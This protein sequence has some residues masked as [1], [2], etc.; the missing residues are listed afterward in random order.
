[1]KNTI[2]IVPSE[3]DCKH[4]QYFRIP[5]YDIF[6]F[7]NIQNSWFV[8]S[9]RIYSLY[10]ALNNKLKGIATLHALTRYVMPPN[11]FKKYIFEFKV[12]DKFK[13]PEKL[14]TELGYERVFNVRE[15]GQFAIRGEIIDFIGANEVPT[16]IELFDNEIEEI[17]EFDPST[18]KSIKKLDLALIL[19]AKEYIGNIT[20][21][22]MIGE[23]YQG[24]ILDYNVKLLITDK[25]KVIDEYIKKERE[26]RDLIIDRKLRHKYVMFSGF[27]YQ[28][29][30]KNISGTFKLKKEG[31]KSKKTQKI[32]KE[33]NVPTIPVISEEEI[34][35]GD[36]VVHKQY[37]IAK[38]SGIRKIKNNNFE[39]EYLIL[40]YKDSKL[41]VPIDRLDLVQKYIG[42]KEA[43]QIDKL[44]KNSWHRRV[45]KA[46]K[47]IEK[48]VKEL[49]RINAI[50]KNTK[51]LVIEGDPELEKEFSDTFPHIETEDQLKAI[52]DVMKDLSS[53]KNMDR[54]VAGDAGYGKTE[55]AMRAA[56][57]V[58]VSGK[59]V[60]VLT[61][62]TVLAR[63]HYEN[64]KKRF[65]KF[66]LKVELY[67]SSLTP[68]QKQKVITDVR[69]GITDIVIG[70]HGIFKSLKFSD[71]GLLII[72]EEQKFGVEQKEALKKLRVNVNIL[73]M[74]A[75]PIPRTL[76]MAL[77]GLKDMSV[78]KTPPFG[79]KQ[80]Q[81]IVSKYDPKIIRQAILR[82]INRGGQVLYVHNRVN[83]ID[84]IA[85]KL[86]EIVPEVSIG[87]AHGQ[88]SKR[89]ME[90]TVHE[91]YN[92][93]IDVLVATTIIENGIDIPNANTLIVDDAHRY[94]ISQLYQLRGRVGRSDK[95]AFAYFLYSG[96]LNKIANERLK[97]I[98]EIVGPGSG[99]QIALRDMEI[100]GIGNILGLEQHGFINDIGLHYYFEILDE[101][102]DELQGK[103][104][105]K[106]ETEISGMQGSVVIPENYIYDP[107]ERIRLYRRIASLTSTDEIKEI[108]EE[109]KDRFGDIPQSV[110]NLLKY[111]KL[112][113][114][115]SKCGIKKI[116]IEDSGLILYTENTL[117]INLPYIYNEKEK[118]YIIYSDEESLIKEL[119]KVEQE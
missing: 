93:N 61:P 28:K 113:I 46:R 50:R 77:S 99:F 112:R 12:G 71:L 82:E 48:T 72:D 78:I 60:A 64:F 53:D 8:K 57:K 14:F 7:E 69:K 67:D 35:I 118:A 111:T 91:F 10:L 21:E 49:L 17:R 84:E 85:A 51:G 105:F 44:K 15:G 73:S 119:S 109:L 33:H 34:K 104:V 81:V 43:V 9:H 106:I 68:K 40:E 11:E 39:R 108:K 87:I 75:T 22:T 107:A 55:V 114:L 116:I 24:T 110:E 66:G 56:F 31:E 79:R 1:M 88:M 101:I 38:F 83:D 16:R 92:G 70:T 36:I 20:H 86:N 62:T 97:A 23:K 89:T 18:Q 98:K 3:K 80:I 54:L 117:N 47:E 100:R 65:E 103:E 52:N 32:Q 37:G 26:I 90:K 74:S 29:I 2:I 63:Q 96:K 30:I 4:T 5:S 41:Y 59:Q 42:V 102:L 115:A 27:D 13:S 76:H 25:D 45:K 94:G 58:A 95:R 19:P 6:P